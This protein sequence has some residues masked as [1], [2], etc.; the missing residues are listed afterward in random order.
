MLSLSPGAELMLYIL[1][2]NGG[3]MTKED[4]E[5]EFKRVVALSPEEFD[6][7]KAR[8]MPL[9]RRRVREVLKGE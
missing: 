7:W 9:V 3:E 2:A 5:R 1:A 8:V 4:A 6:E